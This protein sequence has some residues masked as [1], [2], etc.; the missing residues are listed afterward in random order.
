MAA[1]ACFGNENGTLVTIQWYLLLW[2]L[3]S[4]LGQFHRM[5]YFVAILL[6]QKNEHRLTL[7]SWVAECIRNAPTLRTDRFGCD[8]SR[9][10][11]CMR[12]VASESI[13]REERF[14][15]CC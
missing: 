6:F 12:Q 7:F 14:F 1:R 5:T 2:V 15:A 11:I 9:A 8:S 13:A 10:A 4:F 3:S